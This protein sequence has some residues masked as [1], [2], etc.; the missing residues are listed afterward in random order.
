MTTITNENISAFSAGEVPD[1]NNEKNDLDYLKAMKNHS[2]MGGAMV[3]M[4]EMML[5]FTELAQGKFKQMQDKTAV[6]R[7]ATDLA[8]RVEGIVA[9]LASGEDVGKLPQDVIDYMKKNN[10]LVAGKNIDEYLKANE[11]SPELTEESKKIQEQI[12]FL[13]KLL[14][15]NKGGTISGKDLTDIYTALSYLEGK[16]VKFEG[17]DAN[18]YALSILKYD[19]TTQS[20]SVN[21]ANIQKIRTAL[22]DTF[23]PKYEDPKL[24]KAAL[25][26]IKGALESTATRAT[27]FV[28][29][30]QLKLQQLMQSFNTAV[31]M[32]NA[33]QSMNGEST[34]S[35]AQSIR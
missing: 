28:Q 21:S 16:G 8:N 17:K 29:S 33:V 34:K 32:A 10:I 20:Y 9:K 2:M 31:A 27:D 1:S 12:D 11:I 35:I 24:D 19:K 6:G 15:R 23:P 25:E 26:E 14:A 3:T 4:E 7:D 18:T 13:N 30:S 5:M 22:T